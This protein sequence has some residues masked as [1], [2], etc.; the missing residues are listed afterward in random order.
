MLN[1]KAI[2][3]TFNIGD[4]L[5]NFQFK[6]LVNNDISLNQLR[7]TYVFVVFW[8]SWNAE[9][10]K[11]NRE[12]LPVYSRYK[13]KNFSVGRRFNVV[14][15][16]I[17]ANPKPYELAIKKDNPAWFYHYCDYKGWQTA[18]VKICRVAQIPSNFLLDPKGVVIQKNIGIKELELL[19]N[20]L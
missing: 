13:D 18:P 14:S 3:Q 8:A 4:T 12:L 19:L 5:P 6:G 17:D 20:K 16:S 1:P 10:R 15:V 9:S 2:C 11:L 7:G